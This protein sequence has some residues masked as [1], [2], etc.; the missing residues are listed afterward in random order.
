MRVSRQFIR[1]F[2]GRNDSKERS[3]IPDC[4]FSP[5]SALRLATS[6]RVQSLERS[7]L[8]RS[9][10]AV[11]PP[12]LPVGP[13]RD[14]LLALGSHVSVLRTS[15]LWDTVF[16]IR[17]GP[18]GLRSGW[19]NGRVAPLQN[20]ALQA[21]FGGDGRVASAGKRCAPGSVRWGKGWRPVRA[22]TFIE[23]GCRRN[24][25]S[26]GPTRD[27][28]SGAQAARA[29]QALFGFFWRAAASRRDNA[30]FDENDVRYRL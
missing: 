3:G 22:D 24:E 16:Y 8:Q 23:P 11:A 20:A 5:D 9:D 19:G 30:C 13:A 10:P 1:K 29:L 21:L 18:T 26:V 2:L 12:P 7:V 28:F 27:V 25:R 4:G 15:R 14:A 6:A 17:A